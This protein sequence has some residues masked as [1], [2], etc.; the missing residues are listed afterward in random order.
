MKTVQ[1]RFDQHLDVTG[2]LCVQGA[3]TGGATVHK[4]G[5]LIVQGAIDGLLVIEEGG[6]VHVQGTF[7]SKLRSQSVVIIDGCITEALP[8]NEGAVMVSPGTVFTGGSRPRLLLPNGS[9]EPL[10]GHDIKVNIDTSHG[11]LRLTP[12]GRFVKAA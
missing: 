4:G 9:V 12:E 5:V 6:G 3:V 10:S 1:G 2:H 8:C 11:R 7:S